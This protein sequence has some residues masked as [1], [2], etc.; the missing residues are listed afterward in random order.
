MSI[1]SEI[2]RFDWPY[3]IA[4]RFLCSLFQSRSS[5]SD[6]TGAFGPSDASH[7]LKSRFIPYLKTTEQF[8]SCPFPSDDPEQVFHNKMLFAGSGSTTLGM[9]AGSTMTAPSLRR[10]SI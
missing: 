10:T 3:L 6:L 5:V 2:S 8:S 1:S 7:L 9:F 4:P